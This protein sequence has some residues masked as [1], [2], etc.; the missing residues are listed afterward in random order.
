MGFTVENVTSREI[1]RILLKKSYSKV[2]WPNL[3][4]KS[5]EITNTTCKLY[6]FNT[7]GRLEV[8]IQP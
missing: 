4:L 2:F 8:E 1:G 7:S 3:K 5:S 6:L